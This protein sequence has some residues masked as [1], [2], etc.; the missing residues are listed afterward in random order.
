MS[1]RASLLLAAGISL[2]CA[3]PAPAGT[4]PCRDKA[5]KVIPCPKVRKASPRCKDAS[6]KFVACSP[7]DTPAA[8][9]TI[10]TS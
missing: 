6:G 4:K 8:D 3:S 7:A 5:G 1:K 10:G 2:A 9:K